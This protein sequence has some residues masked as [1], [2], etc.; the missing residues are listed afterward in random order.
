MRTNKFHR[1][2]A[3]RGE[4]NACVMVYYKLF[5]FLNCSMHAINTLICTLDACEYYSAFANT[6]KN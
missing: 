4:N 1:W 2:H 6:G 3:T 5:L